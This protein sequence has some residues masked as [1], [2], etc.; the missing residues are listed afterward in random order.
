M[1]S[2]WLRKMRKAKVANYGTPAARY[3]LQN[4]SFISPDELLVPQDQ[5]VDN[6]NFSSADVDATR[7]EPTKRL[8]GANLPPEDCNFMTKL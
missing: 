1:A 6:A 7:T 2:R 5:D 8:S 3:A 4:S